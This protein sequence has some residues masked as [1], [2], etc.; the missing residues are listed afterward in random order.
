MKLPLYFFVM[1][2]AGL[3]SCRSI[4]Y[5]PVETVRHDSLLVIKSHRDSIYHRDSIFVIERGDTRIVYRNRYLY[6][7]RY[8]TDTVFRSVT[9]TLS[10]RDSI[11]HRDSIF[12]IERGDTRIVYRNRYLYRD[13]Y[14]TD[15]VFRSVTD[16]LSV[17][18][19][20]EKQLSRWQQ[21]KLAF[22]DVAL[23]AL[24]AI[25]LLWIVRKRFLRK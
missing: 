11:Y 9:D 16:T 5:V 4:Q 17:P 2:L 14:L 20:V 13:R 3:M 18:Y 6:R 22:A 25:L 12:V 10:V 8:L 7:D 23:L 15:T 24:I 21:L 1:L 19:P